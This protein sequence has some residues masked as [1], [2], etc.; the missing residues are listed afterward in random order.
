MV[1]LRRLRRLIDN[2]VR[3]NYLK[4]YVAGFCTENGYPQIEARVVGFHR[5]KGR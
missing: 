2:A 1:I 4:T 3:I 5:E